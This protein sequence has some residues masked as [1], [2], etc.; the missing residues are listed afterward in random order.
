V[1]DVNSPAPQSS[2]D[3]LSVYPPSVT[4][5]V[6]LSGAAVGGAFLNF[7]KV[8]AAPWWVRLVFFL[9]VAAF[10]VAVYYGVHYIFYLNEVANQT[11]RATLIVKALQGASAEQKEKLNSQAA[12][13]NAAIDEAWDNV[14]DAHDYSIPAFGVGMTL[15]VVLLG[16]AMIA[17]PL[18]KPGEAGTQNF[19]SAPRDAAS[20]A[21]PAF[22]ITQS[23]IH[24]TGHGREA[25]TFLLNK[26]SGEVWRM[27]CRKR[28]E[29]EF[30]RVHRVGFNGQPE[31]PVP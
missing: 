10:S 14:G 27:I 5:L 22:E 30:Q 4:W 9:A 18:P 7:D 29:V 21:T 28:D 25:H 11:E 2:R 19:I 8:S 31:D 16:L 13:A 20:P 6:G 23:A 15:S 3:T 17:G 1:A 26:N 24:A 12:Q